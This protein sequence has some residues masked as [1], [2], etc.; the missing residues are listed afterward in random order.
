[1]AVWEKRTNWVISQVSWTDWTAQDVYYG[2]EHSFQYSANINCDDEMHGIKLASLPAFTSNFAAC[3]LVSLWNNGVMALPATTSSA[4]KRFEYTGSRYNGSSYVAWTRSTK[5]SNAWPQVRVSWLNTCP[6]VV[7]QDKFW[8]WVTSNGNSM[9]VNVDPSSTSSWWDAKVFRP[10]DHSDSTDDSIKDKTTG[11][12]YYF[13]WAITAILNYNNTRLVVACWQDIWVYYPELDKWPYDDQPNLRGATWWKRTLH[14]E[15]WVSIVGLTCTF[16]YLKVWCVDEWRSTK[17]YYYQGNNNLR[18][19]FVYNEIDLTWEKVLRVYSINSVDYYITSID[20]TDGNVNLNKMI[21]N[22]P[23]QLFHERWGL[24]PL[25]I[26][27]KAPYFVWPCGIN[28]AYKSWRFY[29]ADAYWVFQFKQ[30]PQSFDK[31]YMKWK[32]RDQSTLN[33]Q[34]WDNRNTKVYWVCENKWIL[35][36]SDSTWCWAMRIYDTGVEWYSTENRSK[37]VL[38]SREYEGKEWGTFTKML[39]EVRLNYELNPNA[40]DDVWKITIYVSP[41]NLW[42]STS[43]FTE[44]NNR[45][46]VMTIDNNSK[47]TRTEKSNLL[48]N[49]WGSS[50]SSFGFDRQTITYAIVMEQTED[51][52][53]TPIVRQIDL[54]YHTK[55]KVNNVYDIN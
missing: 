35:Y 12:W 4:P 42:K 47:G 49:L 48:N 15:N 45:Y 11:N 28:A 23:V 17:I 7:F 54:R 55:D 39:D 50:K 21:G 43:S 18:D 3:Q 1:M 46:K 31:G 9:I 5:N 6:W 16:E 25:D 13:T 52:H 53:A 38:I 20:G 29:I 37:G 34:D 19:T 27:F 36:V 32:L 33:I 24:D 26:N 51:I 22:V 14:Y 30:T 8:Y 2:L 40:W 41:N 10:Q 44:A